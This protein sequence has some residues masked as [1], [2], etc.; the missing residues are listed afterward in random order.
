MQ[1]EVGPPGRGVR[2]VPL[3]RLRDATGRVTKKDLGRRKGP[4]TL[5]NWGWSRRDRR[6][7]VVKGP[8]RTN[9]KR[10]R[11]HGPPE[12]RRKKCI[13][14]RGQEIDSLDKGGEWETGMGRLSHLP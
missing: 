9:K 6:R 7:T 2:L 14:R 1:Y 3:G 12:N 13:D 5:E 8:F 11:K 10:L 4:K